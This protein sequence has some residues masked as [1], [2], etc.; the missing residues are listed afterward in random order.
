MS[1]VPDLLVVVQREWN[2]WQK[3]MTPLSALEDIHWRQPAGAPRPLIHAYVACEALVSGDVPHDCAGAGPG[4]R[5]LVCVFKCHT[6]AEAFQRLV[7]R[8]APQHQP[9]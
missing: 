5:L 3:A 9:G 7:D 6:P 8:A 4:H 2:G 1:T